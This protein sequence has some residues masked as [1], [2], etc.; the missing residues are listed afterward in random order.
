MRQHLR[1]F[2]YAVIKYS[3][4]FL[5]GVG[6]T[7]IYP[8][9]VYGGKLN[10][11]IPIIKNMQLVKVVLYS[12]IASPLG[13]CAICCGRITVIVAA[14]LALLALYYGLCYI[15]ASYEYIWIP[16]GYRG[17]KIAVTAFLWSILGFPMCVCIAS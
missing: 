10:Y 16:E 11:I 14:I 6:L 5:L 2:I 4:F 12:L 13:R 9:H 1:T 15:I 17:D 3:T 8:A 7:H